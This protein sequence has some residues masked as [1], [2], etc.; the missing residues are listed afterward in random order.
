METGDGTASST[1]CTSASKPWLP[2]ELPADLLQ[3][4]NLA[5]PNLQSVVNSLAKDRFP[6]SDEQ[7]LSVDKAVSDLYKNEKQGAKR[8]SIEKLQ[9]QIDCKKKILDIATDEDDEE[10]V[11]S[12]TAKSTPLEAELTEAS[13]STLTAAAR[14]ESLKTLT[15]N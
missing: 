11:K 14:V 13:K 3:R 7:K 10:V 2:R 12:T 8:E 1:T 4:L 15:Q 6:A 9:K 5:L